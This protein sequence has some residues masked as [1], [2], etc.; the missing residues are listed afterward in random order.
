MTVPDVALLTAPHAI[1]FVFVQ[2]VKL[3]IRC[4]A[5]LVDV[6]REGRGTSKDVS[7]CPDSR[8]DTRSSTDG[9]GVTKTPRVG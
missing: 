6:R 1:K 5:T 9:D 4:P 2:S 8:R 3:N 7:V